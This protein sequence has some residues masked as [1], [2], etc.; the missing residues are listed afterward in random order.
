MIRVTDSHTAARTQPRS[1]VEGK[2]RVQAD[3]ERMAVAV[4]LSKPRVGGLSVADAEDIRIAVLQPEDGARR[5]HAA[6]TRTKR[7]YKVAAR[8]DRRS[9]E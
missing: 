3:S 1:Q 9:G 2:Q 8:N 7:K 4:W 5:G 6:A